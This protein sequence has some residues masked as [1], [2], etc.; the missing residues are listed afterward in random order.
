MES[1]FVIV[2]SDGTPFLIKIRA[3]PVSEAVRT[4]SENVTYNVSMPAVE[5]SRSTTCALLM[6][7]PTLSVIAKKLADS[8]APALGLL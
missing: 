8:C 3:L 7:G 1:A 6:S 5:A 2:S 4:G